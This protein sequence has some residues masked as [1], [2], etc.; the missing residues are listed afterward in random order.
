MG[1]KIADVTRRRGTVESVEM[2]LDLGL[3]KKEHDPPL[4]WT[5][6]RLQTG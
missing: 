6:R 5:S 3:G 1:D 4:S 2:G